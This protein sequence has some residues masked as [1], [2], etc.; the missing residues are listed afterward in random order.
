MP[1][2]NVSVNV[3]GKTVF[4]HGAANAPDAVNCALAALS[5]GMAHFQALKAATTPPANLSGAGQQTAQ[6]QKGPSL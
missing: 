5:L 6:N 1:D 3:D 4:V 2:V